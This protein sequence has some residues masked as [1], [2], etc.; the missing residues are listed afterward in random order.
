MWPPPAPSFVNCS[1]KFTGGLTW[2]QV[3]MTGTRLLPE[4][5]HS[6]L[7]DFIVS[8]AVTGSPLLWFVI[9]VL[10]ET[11]RPLV[12]FLSGCGLFVTSQPWSKFFCQHGWSSWCLVDYPCLPTC[13][14]CETFRKTASLVLPIFL[15]GLVILPLTL[16]HELSYKASERPTLAPLQLVLV[17]LCYFEDSSLFVWIPWLATW[18]TSE[19]ES[20]PFS[21]PPPYNS[22]TKCF[23]WKHQWTGSVLNRPWG[24]GSQVVWAR[25]RDESYHRTENEVFSFLAF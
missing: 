20:W 12:A 14:N 21:N 11:V 8:V 13:E 16:A 22:G 25:G 18:S 3:W 23:Q 24:N 5:P 2:G 17:R 7:L 1:V 10:Y 15:L 6:L 19:W 4:G 9:A